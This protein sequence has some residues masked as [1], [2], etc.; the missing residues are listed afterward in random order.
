MRKQNPDAVRAEHD[1]ITRDLSAW[2]ILKN[3]EPVAKVTTRYSGRSNPNGVSCTAFVHVLGLPMVR[4]KTGPGGGYDMKSAAV[5]AAVA[6]WPDDLYQK[7]EHLSSFAREA[8]YKIYGRVGLSNGQTWD[9][10][11]RAAGYTVV[12][13]L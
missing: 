4:G 11:V 5:E 1:R 6:N 3:G 12:E 8:V 7:D 2:L 10:Q 9:A 13:V